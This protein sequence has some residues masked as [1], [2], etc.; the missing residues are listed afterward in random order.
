MILDYEQNMSNLFSLLLFSG[1]LWLGVVVSVSVP[2]VDQIEMFNHFLYLKLLNYVHTNELTC[3]KI[4][5]VKVFIYKSYIKFLTL[6]NLQG[7]IYN[8]I[9]PSVDYFFIVL[10]FISLCVYHH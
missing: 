3:L 10:D 5:T 2:S 9:Q 1:P 7:L 4:V 6:N 8:K